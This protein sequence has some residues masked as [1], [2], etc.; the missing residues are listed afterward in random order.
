MTKLCYSN[1]NILNTFDSILTIAGTTPKYN[2][3]VELLAVM[4]DT[5]TGK[6]S[7]LGFVLGWKRRPAQASSANVSSVTA[8]PACFPPKIQ[9]A[10]ILECCE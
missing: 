8:R 6:R 7:D 4:G 10:L 1:Q 5:V 9:G 3:A 2:V